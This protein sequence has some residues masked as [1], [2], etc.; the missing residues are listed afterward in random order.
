MTEFNQKEVREREI[1]LSEE[2]SLL[3]KELEEVKKLLVLLHNNYN[4]SSFNLD[5]SNVNMTDEQKNKTH[6]SSILTYTPL[7]STGNEGVQTNKQTDKYIPEMFETV[8]KLKFEL[9]QK[10]RSLTKQEF[11]VFSAIYLLEEEGLVDYPILAQKLSLSES[12]I[13]DYIMKLQ[14]KGIPIIKKRINNKKVILSIRKELK[15]LV[16]LDLLVKMRE[17]IFKNF[18]EENFR[19]TE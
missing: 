17:P 16:S 19:L 15:H 2:I 8:N 14:R 13:R 12:A 10:F 7:F 9:K 1:K 6:S 5:L 3:K 4:K 11:K 18:K